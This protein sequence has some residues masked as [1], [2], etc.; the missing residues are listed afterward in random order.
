MKNYFLTIAVSTIKIFLG[1]LL[2][3]GISHVVKGLSFG[4]GKALNIILCLD[5]FPINQEYFG[6]VSIIIN[7]LV[8]SFLIV[9]LFHWVTNKP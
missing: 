6:K 3:F 5:S 2:V 9:V 7:I 8:F 1:I 4:G